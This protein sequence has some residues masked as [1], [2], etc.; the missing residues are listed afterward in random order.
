MISVD[1]CRSIERRDVAEVEA[2]A[3]G[4]RRLRQPALLL[5]CEQFLAPRFRRN[6]PPLCVPLSFVHHQIRCDHFHPATL[7]HLALQR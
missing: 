2:L 3:P 4:K 5:G 7:P 6:P 1:Q